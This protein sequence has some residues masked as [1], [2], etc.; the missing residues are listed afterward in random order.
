MH[1]LKF[2]FITDYRS[3]LDSDELSDI[4]LT[5]NFDRGLTGTYKVHRALLLARYTVINE[6]FMFF[7]KIKEHEVPHWEQVGS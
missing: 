1:A 3:L 2:R 5:V 6:I 7:L 4:K